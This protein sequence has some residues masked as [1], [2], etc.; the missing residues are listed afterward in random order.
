MKFINFVMYL[1]VIFPFNIGLLEL[2]G[3]AI[4]IDILSQLI[5]CTIIDCILI[6]TI[7][8]LI[9]KQINKNIKEN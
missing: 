6:I 8:N 1:I 5:L 4:T 3:R 9:K 2:L 7:E